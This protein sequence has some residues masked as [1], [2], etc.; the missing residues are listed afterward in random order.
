[1]DKMQEVSNSPRKISGKGAGMQGPGNLNKR[2]C[3]SCCASFGN[4][5][6]SLAQSFEVRS[7]NYQGMASKGA[8][9]NAARED[10]EQTTFWYNAQSRRPKSS[11]AMILDGSRSQ[12]LL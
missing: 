12:R 6:P 7:N 1:M 5:D 4:L 8:N 10:V 3:L 2:R 11:C 9:Q